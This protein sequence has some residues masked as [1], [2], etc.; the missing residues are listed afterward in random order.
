MFFL[1]E[2]RQEEYTFCRLFILI[3]SNTKEAPTMPGSK[4]AP[5]PLTFLREGYSGG[6]FFKDL[7]A[8]ISAAPPGHVLPALSCQP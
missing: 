8:G 4:L 1:D 5:K 6:I 2:P 3:L 7:T